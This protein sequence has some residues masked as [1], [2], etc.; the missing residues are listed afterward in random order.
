MK[1]WEGFYKNIIRSELVKNGDRILLAVSGGADSMSMLHMFWR[2]SKKIKIDIAVLNLNHGLRKESS[3]EAKQ[4][5]NFCK[6]LAITCM[7]GRLLVKEYS[8][9]AKISI[10]TAARELRYAALEDAATKHKF[11]KIATA[12]NANDNA[13]TVLMWLLRGSGNFSGIPQTRKI[14]K[15]IEIIRPLLSV[16]RT[17]I[18][19]YVKK[20]KLPFSTDK[21]NFSL[22]Y[23]RN[24]IRHTVVPAVEKINPLALE[25]IFSLSRIQER[26]D[27]YLE[28]ISINFLKK[29]AKISKNRILLDLPTFLRYNETI[30]FRIL[31][32]LIPDKKYSAVIDLISDKILSKDKSVFKLSSQW[33]FSVKGN[34]AVFSKIKK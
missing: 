11:N 13:E 33:S 15:K 3:R 34:K 23:T 10:E 21:S 16:R 26:E 32:N 7:L 19:E 27:A 5:L 29:C 17:L 30:R 31:K 24:K 1:A 14:S 28:A 4:V 20:Q 18:D 12:H 2:L 6:K 22:E 9:A 8:K 25:R